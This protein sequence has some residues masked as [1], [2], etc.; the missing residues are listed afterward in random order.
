MLMILFTGLLLFIYII[1][2]LCL[3]KA[4]TSTNNSIVESPSDMKTVNVIIPFRNEETSL[5]LL[6]NS[7][8]KQNYPKDLVKYI[9]VNDHSTDKGVEILNSYIEDNK[10]LPIKVHHLSKETTGKKSALIMA[11]SLVDSEI[12]MTTDADCILHPDWIKIA[13]KAFE[14]ERL[15]LLC[16]GVKISDQHSYL[17]RFQSIE[18]MSLVGSGAG[19]IALKHPIM[20]NGAN[21]AFRRTVLDFL[22]F[23]NLKVEIASG[24]DVFL[25]NSIFEKYGPQSIKFEFSPLFW[26]NTKAAD[27]L[28]K[29]FQQRIR[30]ASKAKFYPYYYQKL[31]GLI[32]FICNAIIPAL[33]IISMFLWNF[34]FLLLPYWI[35][36]SNV[37]F[38]FLKKV[39][40]MSQQELNKIDY[41]KTAIVYPFFISFVAI[42]SQF[43]HFVWK[44]RKY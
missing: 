27:S 32:V 19:A 31:T 42:Y 2:I 17:D 26:V 13:V 3:L 9:F 41:L 12:I 43:G 1:L 5:I 20:S 22:D 7:I 28:N 30:W 35:L 29:L 33:L 15:Q 44:E 24:D 11:R 25:M 38:L 39:A 16:G 36:K 21:I 40:D 37:D 4:I 23:S 8:K 14:E 34:V 10:D 6:L 18:L